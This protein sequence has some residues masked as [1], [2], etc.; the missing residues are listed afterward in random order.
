MVFAYMRPVEAL[1]VKAG[2]VQL[3]LDG[4]SALADIH[5]VEEAIVPS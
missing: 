4:S 3:V 5:N 2:T 1:H